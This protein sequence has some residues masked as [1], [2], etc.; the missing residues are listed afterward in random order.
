MSK[1]KDI[2]P[3][4]A[5]ILA[6]LIFGVLFFFILIMGTSAESWH[7]GSHDSLHE[8]HNCKCYERLVAADKAKEAKAC[9]EK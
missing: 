2:H 9:A 3:V 5:I 7:A 8:G 4:L 6:T 1:N